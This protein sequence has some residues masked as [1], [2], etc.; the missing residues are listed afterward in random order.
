M[1]FLYEPI[2]V[3]KGK[4]KREKDHI[5]NAKT[6][7]RLGRKHKNPWK[8][9]LLSMIKNNNFPVFE[10]IADG[11]EEWEALALEGFLISSIGKKI[12]KPSQGPLYNSTDED[13]ERR[14]YAHSE[15]HRMSVT[16]NA[17]KMN[18]MKKAAGGERA[19]LEL[20][21][22]VE[23]ADE[24]INERSKARAEGAKKSEKLKASGRRNGLNRR[25]QVWSQEQKD[26]FSTV[27]TEL[28]KDP[29]LRKQVTLNRAAKNNRTTM[30]HLSDELK[31]ELVSRYL[32]GEIKNELLE[33]LKNLGYNPTK[34]TLEFL[35]KVEKGTPQFSEL[36][37]IRTE[38]YNERQKNITIAK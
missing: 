13:G 4:R 36:C 35:P 37:R 11:L 21:H 15:N 3:G 22:G 10:V 5:K 30:Y 14:S 12:T 17:N 8:K 19:Y 28:F 23:R 26:N 2:Y 6:D 31:M 38:K 16:K 34:R 29:E 7:L 33:H 27:R 25:G 20:L 18:E 24:I 32:S 9:K 1:S